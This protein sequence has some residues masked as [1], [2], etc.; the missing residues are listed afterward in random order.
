MEKRVLIFNK[1]KMISYSIHL[2]FYFEKFHKIT[3]TIS[4]EYY[5]KLNN[6]ECSQTLAKQTNIKRNM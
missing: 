2:L 4:R 6:N 3:L 5:M 1:R